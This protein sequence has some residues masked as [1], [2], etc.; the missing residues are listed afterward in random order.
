VDMTINQEAVEFELIITHNVLSGT[1]EVSGHSK[2]RLVALGMLEYAKG[3]IN[4][5][6]AKQAI[7][8]DMKNSPLVI[9]SNRLKQ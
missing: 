5:E 4:R 8:D 9:P 3:L 1:F 7:L 2:N 6:N